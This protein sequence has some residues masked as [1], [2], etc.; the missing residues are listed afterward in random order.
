MSIA[1]MLVPPTIGIA[2]ERL[3]ESQWRRGI[4]G[5]MMICNA[6]G[7]T[8][9]MSRLEQLPPNE[10]VLI[11]LGDLNQELIGEVDDFLERG[12]AVLVASDQ[13]DTFFRSIV[14]LQT[15]IGFSSNSARAR[16]GRDMYGGM[17]ECPVVRD[18]R[19]HAV[20]R[21]VRS[22]ATNRPGILHVT[23]APRSATIAFFPPLQNS[24]HAN[25]LVAA[26]EDVG[27]ANGRLIAVADHSI[28]TNQMIACKDNDLFA[29]QSL[30]WLK[31]ESRTNVL[32][33]V[34]GEVLPPLDPGNVEVLPPPPSAE[35]V[36]EALKSLPPSA[37]REFGN[38]VATV[39]EDQNMANEFIHDSL[40]KV[41]D[42]EMNRFLIFLFFGLICLACIVAFA[43][44]KSLMRQTASIIA[45]QRKQRELK[46]R[47]SQQMN[48][49]QWAAG[50]I[51]DSICIEAA[52]RRFND[53]PGF[54][55]GLNLDGDAESRSIFRSMTR[56]SNLFKS[57]PASYWT[58][59]RLQE[60]EQ[61]MFAWRE[62]FHRRDS[63]QEEKNGD[64]WVLASN[65]E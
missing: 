63:G 51:L 5:F 7:L 21:G 19:R 25:S 49:R 60:L 2:Q 18:F 40:D 53:W 41:S 3:T 26:V 64:D 4:H 46:N 35:E 62:F 57:K 24:T 36:V 55:I 48:E 30:L 58:R 1:M 12:G 14:R 29:Y 28:F 42:V 61:E 6:A 39:I 52:D 65:D 9:S 15:G 31:N 34:D 37:L 38:S 11:C 27:R 8:Q 22:L 56:A 23:T 59:Q 54:P 17:P 13:Q 50:I 20:F 45:A 32:V 47:K 10:S 16:Y 33:I 44:Q 43:W